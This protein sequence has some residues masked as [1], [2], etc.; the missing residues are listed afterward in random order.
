MKKLLIAFLALALNCLAVDYT[1]DVPRDGTMTCSASAL[2]SELLTAITSDIQA[3]GYTTLS[4]TPGSS[5]W[6]IQ[7]PTTAQG[8]PGFRI[9]FTLSGTNLQ[10]TIKNSTGTVTHGQV[11]HLSCSAGFNYRWSISSQDMLFK[12]NG[13]SS[14]FYVGIP[15]VPSFYTVP[16]QAYIALG[17]NSGISSYGG[18]TALHRCTNLGYCG[19]GGNAF[20]QSV[21]WNGNWVDYGDANGSRSAFRFQLPTSFGGYYD[22]RSAPFTYV[23]G[24]YP[25]VDGLYQ[26]TING[27]GGTGADSG[28]ARIW[29]TMPNTAF[30]LT[31]NGTTNFPVDGTF[32]FDGKTWRI[33][34][35]ASTAD[36][37]M[38][39]RIA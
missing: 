18:R 2:G 35:D 10:F 34:T 13:S 17:F 20:Q 31:G 33:W 24:S 14:Y 37:V 11:Y 6:N 30:I 29:G 36:I 9:A 3:A 15:M 22:M 25:V 32:T 28:D 26:A 27:L 12:V 5:G 8:I 38:I 4:G 39:R 23:D 7:A 19:L 21:N 1:A 16:S